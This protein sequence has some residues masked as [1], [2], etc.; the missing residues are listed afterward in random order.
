MYI[1]MGTP[2]FFQWFFSS[3]NYMMYPDLRKKVSIVW[4]CCLTLLHGYIFYFELKIEPLQS[5]G[6]DRINVNFS[7]VSAGWNLSF[8]SLQNDIIDSDDEGF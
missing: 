3:A 2:L 7:Q 4:R 5:G 8:G 1:N 6:K